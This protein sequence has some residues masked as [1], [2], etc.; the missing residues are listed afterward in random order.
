MTKPYP[1]VTGFYFL[2]SM[3]FIFCI[4]RKLVKTQWLKIDDAT[5]I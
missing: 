4:V 2:F 5:P 3:L 1:E